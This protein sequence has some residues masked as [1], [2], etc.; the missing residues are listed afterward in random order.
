MAVHKTGDKCDM[1]NHR[2]IT[3]TPPLKKLSW[4]ADPRQGQKSM[5]SGLPPR[6]DSAPT[7]APVISTSTCILCKR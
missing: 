4:S 3:V 7:N 6:Q 5:G 1:A 2:R